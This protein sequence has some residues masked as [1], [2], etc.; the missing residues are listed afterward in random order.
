MRNLKT[1][2]LMVVPAPEKLMP[3]TRIIST[4]TDRGICGPFFPATPNIGKHNSFHTDDFYFVICDPLVRCLDRRLKGFML[5][6]VQKTG[7]H[8]F[9][10]NKIFVFQHFDT[11]SLFLTI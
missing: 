5:T 7:R 2:E 11:L 1:L 3:T 8:N 4:S 10:G 9:L 6:R